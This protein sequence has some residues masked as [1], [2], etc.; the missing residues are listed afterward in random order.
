MMVVVL[1][2]MFCSGVS[3]RPSDKFITAMIFIAI[4]IITMMINMM[5][6]SEAHWKLFAVISGI[7]IKS[8]RI[9]EES[10]KPLNV[11]WPQFGALFQLTQRDNITQT[12]LA[13]RLETDTTTVMVLCNSMEKKGWIEREKDPSDK[14][15]NRLILTGE[16]KRVHNDAYPLMLAGYASFTQAISED[17]LTAILPILSNLYSKISELHDKEVKQ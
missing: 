10:L 3:R 4:I 8:R 5:D 1:S 14:R 13:E 15:V 2:I 7:Y 9:A 17:E 6:E 16:G 11:T 12:E